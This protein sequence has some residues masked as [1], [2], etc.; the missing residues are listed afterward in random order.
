[1]AAIEISPITDAD[2]PLVAR[3]LHDELNPRVPVD[4]WRTL[5]LPPWDGSPPNHGFLLR[6]EGRVVGAYAAV[7]SVRKIDGASVAVCN[8]A[9]FCVREEHRMHSLRLVRA[10]LKQRDLVFT[11][12]SPSGNVVAMN[13]RLGF[14][15][16]GGGTRLVL[17][18]PHARRARVRVSADPGRLAATLSGR[19]AEV[20]RDH[21][22][23]PAA[24]HVLVQRGD[25]HA[26]LVFRVDSRKRLRLFATP[27][28]V[29][30]NR[31]LLRDV[32]RHVR[33]HL[34][35]AH[36]L[37]FT[38]AEPRLL[39]FAPPLGIA[40]RDPRPR[41]V[42][43]SAWPGSDVDYLYSEFALLEW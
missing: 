19:D 28:Y 21:R 18:L 39:H 6:S 1:M 2:V 33:T 41:M 8:L 37:P 30:G 5:L 42:R 4:A 17:N 15:R 20:Y 25:D 3:F 32:W 40:L 9:A 12:L 14:E 27:L 24:R 29:G 36:R 16:L 38:L 26:Y 23:A 35:V 7:Y 11:D 31:E 34:F 22:A 43:G 13:E 10:L